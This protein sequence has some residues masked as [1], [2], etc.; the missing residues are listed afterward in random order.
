MATPCSYHS[1]Q[2]MMSPG[3]LHLSRITNNHA[4]YHAIQASIKAPASGVI[5]P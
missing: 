1:P 5:F 4:L 2:G 3:Q